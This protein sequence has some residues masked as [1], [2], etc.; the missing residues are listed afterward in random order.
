MSTI[1]S[2]R[3]PTTVET[4]DSGPEPWLW[5]FIL[6]DMS[7]FA[8]FFCA[9]LWEFADEHAAFAA[10]AA[11]LHLTAGFTNTVVLLLSSYA[12]V[13]AVL[14][15]RNSVTSETACW[16]RWALA[17]AGVFVAV[18]AYEYTSG[19]IDGHGLTSTTFDG[20]YYVLT[21]LHLMHVGIGS[22]LLTAWLRSLRP[23]A[24]HASR[25]WTES[26]AAYWHMVDLLWLIIF[27]FVYIGSH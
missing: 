10:D 9:Y 27:A 2:T 4:P 21:G 13:R 16:L 19:V 24:I 5:G 15:Q 17:G 22:I 23:G 20:Y 7:V 12:V 26:A 25:R 1:E 18:K 3:R 14:A 6:A 11:H 8:L